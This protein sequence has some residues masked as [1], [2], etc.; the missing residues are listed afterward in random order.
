[1][2]TGIEFMR[3]RFQSKEVIYEVISVVQYSHRKLRQRTLYGYERQV[4]KAGVLARAKKNIM[5]KFESSKGRIISLEVRAVY[6]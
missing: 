5:R 4:D 1:M 2:K 6:R 3:L